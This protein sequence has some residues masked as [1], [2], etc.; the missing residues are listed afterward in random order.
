MFAMQLRTV[1]SVPVSGGASESVFP[2]V[3]AW[4]EQDD[5]DRVLGIMA[6]SRPAQEYRS[7]VDFLFCTVFP[8]QQ[9][10]CKR[11]YEDEGPQLRTIAS[12][13]QLAV[14]ERWMLQVLAGAYADWCRD[15]R[16]SW[17]Q[18]LQRARRA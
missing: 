3:E 14:Y 1:Q 15:R 10:T 7:V 2:A 5:H 6:E 11:F 18:A 13:R 17:A 12:K 4:L 16:R 8:G 9:A